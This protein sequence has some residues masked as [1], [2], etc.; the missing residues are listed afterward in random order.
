[1]LGS[2][3]RTSLEEGGGLKIYN[4]YP[5]L[6]VLCWNINTLVEIKFPTLCCVSIVR[7][8]ILPMFALLFFFAFSMSEKGISFLLLNG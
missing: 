7:N 8:A 4:G 6:L 1:M 3:W 2:R 5:F